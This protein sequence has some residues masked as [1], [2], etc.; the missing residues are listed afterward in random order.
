[1]P[2]DNVKPS[3]TEVIAASSDDTSTTNRVILENRGPSCSIKNRKLVKPLL[4]F[5]TT[6]RRTQ[7]LRN[8]NIQNKGFRFRST[9]TAFTSTAGWLAGRGTSKN[10]TRFT[11]RHTLP[12]DFPK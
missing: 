2:R 4:S 12:R 5:M 6:I 7:N 8:I 11:Y 1:M 10:R 9:S 3:V